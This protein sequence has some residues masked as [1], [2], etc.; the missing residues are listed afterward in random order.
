MVGYCQPGSID[1]EGKEHL[2][3]YLERPFKN[4]HSWTLFIR[5]WYKMYKT[6]SL[7]SLADPFVEYAQL[8]K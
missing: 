4:A 3:W 8:D 6:S 5:Q 2:C 1:S 7:M